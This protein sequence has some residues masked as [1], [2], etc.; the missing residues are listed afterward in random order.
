MVLEPNTYKLEGFHI[1]LA[2]YQGTMGKVEGIFS[3]P[4]E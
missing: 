2:V 4:L 3:L 1:V